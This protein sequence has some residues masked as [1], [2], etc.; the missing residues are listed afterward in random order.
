MTK[1]RKK[2]T[3]TQF[4]LLVRAQLNYD[5][6]AAEAVAA[7]EELNTVRLLVLDALDVDPAVGSFID[8]AKQELVYKEKE[9]EPEDD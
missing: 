9:P 5:K 2:L 4:R 3:E 7:A 8:A 1:I 6:L